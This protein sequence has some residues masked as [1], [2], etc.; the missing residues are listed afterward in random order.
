MADMVLDRTL[1][2]VK[3]VGDLV[4]GESFPDEH[5]HLG[6][7]IGQVSTPTPGP[8]AAI[9]EVAKEP[10]RLVEIVFA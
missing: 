3:P 7:A 8:K 9:A 5:K 2:D 4:V 1:A 6:F 10:R